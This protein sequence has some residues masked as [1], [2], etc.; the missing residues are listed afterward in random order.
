M[1]NHARLVRAEH[2]GTARAK[3]YRSCRHV[4]G[5]QR[6][7]DNC[8]SSHAECVPALDERHWAKTG[9]QFVDDTGLRDGPEGR[10]GACRN[11]APKNNQTRG[12]TD[13]R[14]QR[15]LTN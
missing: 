4:V 12:I 5:N 8:A 10:K 7:T 14:K 1:T 2:I 15:R 11:S 13:L 3:A 6:G 9:E